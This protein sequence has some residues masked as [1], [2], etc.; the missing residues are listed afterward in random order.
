[1]DTTYAFFDQ[2]RKQGFDLRHTHPFPDH[3]NY[4]SAELE[5]F[6]REAERVG[7]Q[8]LLTT[9]KDAVKL[10]S[11]EFPLP[12]YVVEIELGFEDEDLLRRL[13][14]DAIS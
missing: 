2:L 8:A 14:K 13:V 4:T 10:R 11:Q 6:A 3:H 1:M 7:A 12:C 9:A 5:T